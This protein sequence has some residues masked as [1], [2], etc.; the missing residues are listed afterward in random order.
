[1]KRILSAVI[2]L[3]FV[4]CAEPDDRVNVAQAFM[5]SA[6]AETVLLPRSALRIITSEGAYDFTVELADDAESRK[7]GLMRRQDLAVDAGMLFNFKRERQIS[8]WMKDTY[9]S[10]DMLFIKADGRIANIARNTTPYSLA[11]IHSRVPVLA[12]LEVK[13]GT[14]DR[15]RILPGDRVEHALF[16]VK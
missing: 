8:M 10:L 13:G 3:A 15:L 9:I 4:W 16:G 5:P 7:R 14:A 1:M 11:Y 12:V 2:L 6:A